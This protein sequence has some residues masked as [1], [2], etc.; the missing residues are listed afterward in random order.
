MN[1]S[2]PLVDGPNIEPRQRD[3]FPLPSCLPRECPR[4]SGCC[5]KVRRRLERA[6]HVDAMVEE[7]IQG[8]NAMYSHG[9][10]VSAMPSSHGMSAAQREKICKHSF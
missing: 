4:Q 9:P 8:L 5:R 1:D 2:T 10:V 3:I 7:C 6:S